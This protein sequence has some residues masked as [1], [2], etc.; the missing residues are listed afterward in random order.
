MRPGIVY[1]VFEAYK[2]RLITDVNNNV[3]ELNVSETSI[4]EIF[5]RVWSWS[6]NNSVNRWVRTSSYRNKMTILKTFWNSLDMPMKS[7]YWKKKKQWSTHYWGQ[8]ISFLL[9]SVKSCHTLVNWSHYSIWEFHLPI[10]WLNSL[11]FASSKIQSL[12]C[13]VLCFWQMKCYV[14]TTMVPHKVVPASQTPKV[15]LLCSQASLI[16][17]PVQS[18]TTF[19]SLVFPLPGCHLNGIIQYVG[20]SSDFIHLTKYI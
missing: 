19:W 1:S 4:W 2:S 3:F 6:Q 15:L 20:F 16:S 7:F 11:K 14:S 8:F 12:L 10:V 13:T 18:R 17:N 9:L 5:L